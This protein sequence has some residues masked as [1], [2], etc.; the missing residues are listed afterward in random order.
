MK[1]MYNYKGRLKKNRK[2]GSKFNLFF[3]YFKIN[4]IYLRNNIKNC[5]EDYK[6]RIYKVKRLKYIGGMQCIYQYKY[7][8]CYL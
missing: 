5:G 4:K 1:R 7:T 6:N 2:N 3:I 8:F